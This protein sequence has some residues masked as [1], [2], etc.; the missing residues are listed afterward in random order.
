ML[1]PLIKTWRDE[2]HLYRQRGQED[3]ALF[4]ESLIEEVVCL[5]CRWPTRTGSPRRSWPRRRRSGPRPPP[6][7]TSPSCPRP[8]TETGGAAINR[9]DTTAAFG[10]VLDATPEMTKAAAFGAIDS[11]ATELVTLRVTGGS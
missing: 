3:L 6:R 7:T 9:A 5:L 2:V 11:I 10:V 4:L 1:E 8:V